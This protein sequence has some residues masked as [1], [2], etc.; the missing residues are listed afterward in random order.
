MK[1]S[2]VLLVVLLLVSAG[3]YTAALDYGRP[4]P[5]YSPSTV[6][7]AWLNGATVYHPDAFAYVGLP[8]QMMLQRTFNPRY[9][10]NPSLIIYTNMAMFY[11]SGAL[12]LPHNA[13]YG[14]RE[15]APFSL[16]VMAQYLSALFSLLTVALTYATGRIIFG[17]RAVGLLAA[18]LTAFSPLMVQHAHYAT[19]NPI[20]ITVSTAALLLAVVLLTRR[21]PH[22]IVYGAAGFAVGLTTSG[23]YNAVVIGV[24][25]FLALA[26]VWL[27]NRRWRPVAL[28]LVA[29]PLGFVLG[30]PGAI[31]AFPKFWEDL[32]YILEWYKVQGG[33]AGWDSSSGIVYHWRYT[34][35]FV[36][37]PIAVI[38]A[39][40]GGFAALKRIRTSNWQH[41]W[42][43]GACAIYLAIYTVTAL[44][45]LRLNANLLLPLIVPVAL[46]A[47]YGAVQ[48]SRRAWISVALAAGMLAWPLV[49]SVLFI[50]LLS[51]PD[52][53]MQAQAWIY[54]HVPKGSTI[55]LFGSY[56]VPLDPLDY[57]F[58][59]LYAAFA[60]A[61]D[62]AWNTPV[63]VYSDSAPFSILRDTATS[64]NPQDVTQTIDSAKRLRENYIELARFSRM[65]WPAQDVPPDDVSYW[66]QM[67][68]VIYCNPANCPVAR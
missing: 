6:Q 31:F 42:F 47:A 44:P 2:L 27:R 30:T 60:K 57:K 39:L 49:L 65:A 3:L 19:P 34:V 11:A 8:Y 23:R 1:R 38:L 9:Y 17:S 68:I 37:G 20:T 63:I 7:D 53:R 45:G 43:A 40:V 36:S 61:D 5:E 24:V 16:Y 50:R 12:S 48:M 62:P 22:W 18:A 10:H 59:N 35:L 13:T 46:F 26:T 55:N 51:I 15:I 14:T 58:T 66:H 54:Q 41:A 25:T 29:I 52:T 33:G 64:R 32:R 56:N 21:N 28:A 67:E 4:L